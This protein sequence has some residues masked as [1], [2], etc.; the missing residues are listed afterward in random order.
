MYSGKTKENDYSKP[1]LNAAY[2]CHWVQG[3]AKKEISWLRN[4]SHKA[5]LDQTGT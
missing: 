3:V 4:K 2:S 5:C 1:I